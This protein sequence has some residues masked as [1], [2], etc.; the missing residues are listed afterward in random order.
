MLTRKYEDENSGQTPEDLNNFTDIWNQQ[1]KSLDS[2][3][4]RGVDYSMWI[5]KLI[6]I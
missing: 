6:I 5:N 2:F 3:D 4:T 1:S